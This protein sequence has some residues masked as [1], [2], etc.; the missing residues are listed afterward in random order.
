MSSDDHIVAYSVP[1]FSDNKI[2]TSATPGV[3]ESNPN[4]PFRVSDFT[5]NGVE[6]RLVSWGIRVRYTG[7]DL[8]K[9]GTMY[10]L[11]EPNHRDLDLKTLPELLA[12]ERVKITPVTRA[13]TV[14]NYQPV[15]AGEFDYSAHGTYLDS[16][17]YLAIGIQCQTAN[18]G[19]FA[20]EAFL[21][22][23]AVGSLARGKTSSHVDLTQTS[24]TLS[25][26][27]QKSTIFMDR[28]AASVDST[29]KA[30]ESIQ[31]L[32]KSLYSAFKVGSQFAPLLA[33]VL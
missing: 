27:G 13:W 12:Y 9:N 8:Q 7:T 18:P 3:V 14:V 4:S 2:F 24:N 29:V 5:S 20:W 26:L 21:N 31:G 28:A 17:P 15:R 33:S 6:G 30:V 25:A 23:E 11:E 1:G 10:A 22:F 19:E 16:S 32:G